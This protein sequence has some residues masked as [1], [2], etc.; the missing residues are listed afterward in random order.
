MLVVWRRPDAEV[1]SALSNVTFASGDR[2]ICL[3]WYGD[4]HIPEPKWYRDVCNELSE[5]ENRSLEIMLERYAA[6]S[7]AKRTEG[8]ENRLPAELERYSD[9]ELLYFAFKVA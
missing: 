1:S 9:S 5:E 3:E 8:R 7:A 4:G 6:K 2:V